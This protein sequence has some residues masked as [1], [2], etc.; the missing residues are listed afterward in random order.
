[1]KQ[2]WEFKSKLSHLWSV[3]VQQGCQD[4]L[5]DKGQSHEQMVLEQ[6]I[7]T[8]KGMKLDPCFT[9]YIKINPKWIVDINVTAKTIKLLERNTGIYLCDL[10]IGNGILDMTPKAWVTKRKKQKNWS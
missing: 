3:D 6:Y 4:P 5:V 2:Y 1:M 8:C 9:L 7:A 10:G